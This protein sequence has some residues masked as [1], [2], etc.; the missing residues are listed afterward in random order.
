MR[1]QRGWGWS[2]VLRKEMGG[3][4]LDPHYHVKKKKRHQSLFLLVSFYFPQFLLKFFAAHS[5][6][7]AQES[8]LPKHELTLAN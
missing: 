8:M 7:E 1:L 4:G 6:G 5:H 3:P 2:S